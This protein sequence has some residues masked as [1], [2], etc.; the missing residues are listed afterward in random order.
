MCI[1]LTSMILHR[2]KKKILHQPSISRATLRHNLTLS[3]IQSK[4]IPG[5]RVFLMI[6]CCFGDSKPQ[7]KIT[8][9]YVLKPQMEQTFQK[10]LGLFCE[11]LYNLW[12]LSIKRSNIA[13]CFSPANSFDKFV[14]F[15]FFS[16]QVS[17]HVGSCHDPRQRTEKEYL[18][19]VMENFEKKRPQVWKDS[20]TWANRSWKTNMTMENQA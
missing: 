1:A 10:L 6:C 7:D 18:K 4:A 3:C 11:H 13:I 15:V 8:L 9:T 14:W 19:A 20:F 5:G 2:H 17:I 16:S 12:S